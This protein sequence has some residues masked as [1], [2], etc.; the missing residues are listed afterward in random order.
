MPNKL[1]I[2]VKAQN[3]NIEVTCYVNRFIFYHIV[4]SV[5]LQC[6]ESTTKLTKELQA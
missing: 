1:H 6:I 3:F 4:Q 5:K 2:G